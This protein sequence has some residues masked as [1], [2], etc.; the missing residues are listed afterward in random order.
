MVVIF[1][2]PVMSQGVKIEINKV[3][4]AWQK[5]DT[6]K[7][8]QDVCNYSFKGINKGILTIG[9]HRFQINHLAQL[10]TNQNK[11]K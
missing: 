7:S 8:G 3:L 6:F 10:L 11:T 9:C 5:I 1:E 2:A 4:E